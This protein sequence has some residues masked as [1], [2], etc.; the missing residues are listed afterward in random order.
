MR[1]VQM[2]AAVERIE[3]S[4]AATATC[5]S[6]HC[7]TL[8]LLRISLFKTRHGQSVR[9]NKHQD[10]QVIKLNKIYA[11]QHLGQ[12]ARN[13]RL[14]FDITLGN[15]FDKGFNSLLSLLRKVGFTDTN[16]LRL[17][18]P[19]IS[20]PLPQ[21]LLRD[22]GLPNGLLE[23]FANFLHSLH[24]SR[25]LSVELVVGREPFGLNVGLH[26]FLSA[27]MTNRCPLVGNSSDFDLGR[28]QHLFRHLL[29]DT[30]AEAI[31]NIGAD[32]WK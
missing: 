30:G 9:G 17:D 27:Q 4:R 13:Q 16:T 18:C 32:S 26:E 2:E 23:P 7:H 3:G 11:S 28:A 8:Q 21:G 10:W 6:S 31:V 25:V 12:N 5:S 29:V 20:S 1:V 24:V 19:G 15:F 22:L 14:K